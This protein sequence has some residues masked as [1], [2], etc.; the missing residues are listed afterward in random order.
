MDALLDVFLDLD[1]EDVPSHLDRV[2]ASDPRMRERLAQLLRAERAAAGFLSVPIAGWG[3]EAPNTTVEASGSREVEESWPERV[4]RYRVSNELG[5]GGMGVVL[6]A[7]EEP[8]GRKVAL[9][10][11]PLSWA[12]DASRVALFLRE[13][14]LL[15]AL[16]HPNIAT[17]HGVEQSESGQRFL[18]LE[19]V[20]GETLAQRLTSG[21]MPL[22]LALDVGQQVARGLAAAHERRIIHRDLKP[23]NVMITPSGLVKVLDFGIARKA[24]ATGVRG[25]RRP[26]GHPEP[27]G[28]LGTPGYM[29]PEQILGLAQGAESDAFAFGCVLYECLSG[30]PSFARSNRL[31]SLSATLHAHVDWSKLPSDTPDAV[32]EVLRTCLEKDAALRTID[33]LDVALIFEASGRAD[34]SPPRKPAGETVSVLPAPMTRCIGRRRE[35]EE[36]SLA[37][38]RSRLVTLT[39]A[40]GCGKT[41]IAIEVARALSGERHDVTWFVDLS[42]VT[43]AAGMHDALAGVTGARGHRMVEIADS[44]RSRLAGRSGLLVLDNCEQVLADCTALVSS[45]LERCLMLRILATSREWLGATGELTLR[46]SPLPVPDPEVHSRVESIAANESVSL[47]VENASVA[48]PGFRIDEANAGLVAKICRA[49]DGIPLAIELAAALSSHRS[50]PDL[51]ADFAPATSAEFPENLDDLRQ[52]RLFAAIDLSFRRLEGHERDLFE[53]LAVFSGGWTLEAAAAVSGEADAF[54]VLDRLTRLLDRSL[55]IPDPVP[56]DEPRYRFLEPIRSFARSRLAVAPKRDELLRRHVQHFV[57]FAEGLEPMVLS[58]REQLDALDQFEADHDNVLAAL[59]TCQ[60]E[61][62][63]RATVALR[64]VRASWR[65]WY[66]RGHLAVGR[67]ALQTAL[68]LSQEDSESIARAYALAAAGVLTMYLHD[69][70]TARRFYREAL[71]LHRQGGDEFGEASTLNH[72]GAAALQAG[73]LRRARTFFEAARVRFERL[74]EPRWLALMLNNL[75]AVA[76][77]EEDFTAAS[78]YFDRAIPLA[79][80]VNNLDD[81]GLVLVNS[82]LARLRLGR[83]DVASDR[84]HEAL[85]TIRET[86]ARR[87]ATA[88]L[89]VASQ[90]LLEL[91]HPEDAA[92]LMGSATR[93]RTAI[94]VPADEGWRRSQLPFLLRLRESLQPSRYEQLVHEGTL[95]PFEEVLDH[96]CRL[97]E[98]R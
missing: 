74:Q 90:V 14:R 29:S 41:R 11:L 61:G 52:S 47:F 58:G 57:E 40:G 78:E 60:A 31:A 7:I 25:L 18:V 32:V 44:L 5:R 8:I 43:D 98:S 88:A 70:L 79:R 69:D 73:H 13:A 55:V 19:F 71:A 68:S 17:I 63:T 82:A 80:E 85:A 28:A 65:F 4:G 94:G 30:T 53:A 59:R 20:E 95:A 93:M 64:I 15:G 33:F 22:P 81:L 97:I 75:G 39:G 67:D 96:A 86:G 45:L 9:K 77:Q 51:L 2:G 6:R 92:R 36:C 3:I 76:R 37:L 84:I 83:V 49:L 35:I 1:P 56:R 89:E 62:R 23:S 24:A 50:L 87:A 27:G 48:R 91:G 66:M 46:V 34:R 10:A 16:H 38:T 21:S 12:E 42:H 72:L 26:A 54:Q